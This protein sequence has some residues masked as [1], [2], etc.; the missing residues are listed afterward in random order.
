ML[1]AEV[2][3]KGHEL[4]HR[5]ALGQAVPKILDGVD[6]RHEVGA[7]RVQR[8]TD[9]RIPPETEAEPRDACRPAKS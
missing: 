3:V 7:G 9:R 5:A 2:D 6:G 8:Y 1:G 4:T